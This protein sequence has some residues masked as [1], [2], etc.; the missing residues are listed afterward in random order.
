MVVIVPAGKG[1]MVSRDL[2]VIVNVL[3][4]NLEKE[5][6]HKGGKNQRMDKIKNTSRATV[7]RQS[8]DG[9]VELPL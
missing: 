7:Q 6:H 3:S 9:F 2:F 8:N 4:I 1:R 5:V